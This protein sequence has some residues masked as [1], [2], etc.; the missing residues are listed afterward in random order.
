M[1]HFRFALSVCL[2]GLLVV[3]FAEDTAQLDGDDDDTEP[4][5]EEEEEEESV[6]RRENRDEEAA[7]AE[8]VD[9]EAH[10]QAEHEDEDEEED[11]DAVER[12]LDDADETAG[13]HR[14]QR[15]ARNLLK[16][17]LKRQKAGEWFMSCTVDTNVN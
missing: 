17:L 8:E 7:L 13:L 1:Y 10:A 15:H 6:Q 3:S 16:R 2:L 5:T 11:S 9:D 4:Q 14:K 12:E